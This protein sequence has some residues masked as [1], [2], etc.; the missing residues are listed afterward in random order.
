MKEACAARTKPT[1]QITLPEEQVNRKRERL[2]ALIES[3][4]RRNET[5]IAQSYAAEL[6]NAEIEFELRKK[7]KKLAACNRRF[8]KGISVLICIMVVFAGLTALDIEPFFSLVSEL[9]IMLSIISLIVIHRIIT[10]RFEKAIETVLDRY[11]S[12]KKL[13]IERVFN[14]FTGCSNS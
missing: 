7:A 13:F 12:E 2:L 3:R 6:F 4:I 1:G 9:L 14:S 8:F 11:D 5:D 10:G